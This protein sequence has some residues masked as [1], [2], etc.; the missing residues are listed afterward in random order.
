MTRLTRP[1]ALAV[2]A[3]L[4]SGLTAGCSVTN[5]QETARSYMPSDGVEAQL[6]DGLVATNLLLIAED[7]QSEAVLV[8]RVVNSGTEPAT[9]RIT[10]TEADVDVEV[11]VE[12]GQTYAVGGQDAD[13]QVTIDSLGVMPGQ[14]LPMT[15]GADGAEPVQVSVPVLDGTLPEYADLLP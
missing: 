4:A 1:V 9:V 3:V 13:E 5:P 7:A 11:E 12:P 8:A 6:G 14:R 15:V 10:S 2:A